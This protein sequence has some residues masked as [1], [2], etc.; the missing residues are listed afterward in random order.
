MLAGLRSL[1]EAQPG[2]QPFGLARLFF[3]QSEQHKKK[4]TRQ[5]QEEEELLALMGIEF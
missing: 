2:G 5:Q 1:F 4:K 3:W